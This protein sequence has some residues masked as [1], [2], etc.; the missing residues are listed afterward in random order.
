MTLDE[1]ILLTTKTYLL[2][3]RCQTTESQTAF[4]FSSDDSTSKFHDDTLSFV[5]LTS[6]VDQQVLLACLDTK[7]GLN[8]LKTLTFHRN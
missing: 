6:S 3:N 7:N 2:H 4:I 5:Q 1:T 8:T